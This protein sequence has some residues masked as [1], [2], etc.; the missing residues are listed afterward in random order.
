MD[1][2]PQITGITQSLGAPAGP[3]TLDAQ[4][5]PEEIR[6]AAE[7][8]E[9]VFL[10]EMLRPMFESLQTDGMFGGG[11]SER[12]Y[13]SFMVQEYGKSMAKANSI[14]IA[15]MVERELLKM[16]EIDQ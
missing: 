4:A 11:S 12:V 14:G 9:A 8:F 16:Q 10:A 13:Q 7:D 1:L 15:D 3:P 2:D 6:A 5:S